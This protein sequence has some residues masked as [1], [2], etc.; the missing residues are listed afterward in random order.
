MSSITKIV[1]PVLLN[2]NLPEHQKNIISNLKNK[3][4]LLL[5]ET[6]E[7]NIKS[8]NNIFRKGKTKKNAHA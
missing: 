7:N 1:K 6:Q 2:C 8:K 4:I 3:K 5:Q